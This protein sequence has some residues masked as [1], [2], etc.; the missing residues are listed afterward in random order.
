MNEEEV[1]GGEKRKR[2]GGGI[3]GEAARKKRVR[4]T[5]REHPAEKQVVEKPITDADVI[6]AAKKARKVA[7]QGEVDAEVQTAATSAIGTDADAT[8][9][10]K[11][12]KRRSKGTKDRPEAAGSSTITTVDEGEQMAAQKAEKASRQSACG[13]GTQPTNTPDSVLDTT[14]ECSS[15]KR[16]RKLTKPLAKE[17][18]GYGATTKPLFKNL[19]DRPHPRL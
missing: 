19:P 2:E 8:R 6:R 12:A 7:R 11:K 4:F 10:A 14:T 16:R 18:A 1:R 15:A 3:Q 17:R 13:L 9:A 5:E